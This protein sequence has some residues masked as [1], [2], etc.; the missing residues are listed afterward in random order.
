[1]LTTIK[2]HVHDKTIALDTNTFMSRYRICKERKEHDNTPAVQQR[3]AVHAVHV[4]MVDRATTPH[5]SMPCCS[6]GWQHRSTW[7]T[8]GRTLLLRPYA[9]QVGGLR[10]YTAWGGLLVVVSCFDHTVPVCGVVFG[11]EGGAWTAHRCGVETKHTVNTQS[12]HSR[13]LPYILCHVP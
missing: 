6:H 9:H 12:T 1:M 5:A 7:S 4:H 2:T 3:L 10:K 11:G 13:H 8:H